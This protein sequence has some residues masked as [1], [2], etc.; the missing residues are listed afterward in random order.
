MNFE[1]ELGRELRSVAGGTRLDEVPI[2]DLERLGNRERS[3][4]HRMV[5][6]ITAGIA[7]AAVVAAVAV[8][9]L[10]GGDRANGPAGPTSTSPTATTAPTSLADLPLGPGSRVPW[11]QAGVLHIGDTTIQTA[12]RVLVY[13]GGTTVVGRSSVETGADWFV[14]DGDQLTPLVSSVNPFEPVISADGKVIAWSEPVG[15]R[16]RRVVAYDVAS[17]A[18][19][20]STDVSVQPVCCDA[21]GELF[22]HGIDLSG[23]VFF[24]KLGE[25]TEMWT[26]G[27]ETVEVTG[28]RNEPMNEIWP[29]GVMFQGRGASIFEV[30]GV[31]GTVAADGKFYRVGMVPDDQLGTWSADGSAYAHPGLADGSVPFKESLDHQ[32]VFYVGSEDQVELGLPADPNLKILAWEST[33]MVILQARTDGQPQLVRCD[34]I[35]GACERA[36]DSLGAGVSLPSQR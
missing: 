3:R 2:H 26:P 13:A 10:I 36:G 27:G 5:G 11:W 6:G 28:L 9:A 16:L 29:G 23:R 35:S 12:D 19:L 30:P 31:F 15:D 24:S 25:G 21:G 8:P 22:I 1:D 17:H 14:V 20:G 34:A 33:G 4:R 7:A 32:W 18:V